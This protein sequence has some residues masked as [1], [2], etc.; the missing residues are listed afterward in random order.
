MQERSLNLTFRSWHTVYP[1]I[2]LH[3]LRERQYTVVLSEAKNLYRRP[4]EPV[5]RDVAGLT[6]LRTDDAIQSI[7]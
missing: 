1:S 5:R 7:Y 3:C 2:F 4:L 6:S